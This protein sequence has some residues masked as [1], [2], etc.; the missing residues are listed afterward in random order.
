MF[1]QARRPVTVA[2]TTKIEYN[3]ASD[4]RVS[5]GPAAPRR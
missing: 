2:Q 4:I 1:G 5:C 3:A